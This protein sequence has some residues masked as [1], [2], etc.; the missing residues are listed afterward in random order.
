[1]R[2]QQT[3]NPFVGCFSSGIGCQ[4]LRP[5]GAWKIRRPPGS[6][7]EDEM[8]RSAG[9]LASGGRCWDGMSHWDGNGSDRMKG[10]LGSIRIISPTYI[11]H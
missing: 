1:M 4:E 11:V 9:A 2:N 5:H 3:N 6:V 8:S 10:E 7:S